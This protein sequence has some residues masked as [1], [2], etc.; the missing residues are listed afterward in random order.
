ME[1]SKTYR[2]LSL[3]GGGSWALTQVKCLRKLFAETFQ[4]PDPTGH[5]V[6]AMF[7]LV[8]ANSGGSLVAA[9]MAEDM[10][11]SQIE[12]IFEEENL[13][14][15][16][17]AKLG[18]FEK[19]LL[20]N[21]ARIFNIGA[22]Y[23]TARKYTALKSMLPS[24]A[25]LPLTDVPKFVA[26]NQVPKTQFLIIAYDYYRNRA[27][28]FRS[29]CHSRAATDIISHHLCQT[30]AKNAKEGVTLVDAIHASSTAPVNYFNEPAVFN[31]NQRQKHYWDGG[32]TGNNN[33]VLTAVTEAI[34]NRSRYQ[35]AHIQVLSL[36][37]G[38]VRQLQADEDCKVKY[39]DLKAKLVSPGL[40]VDISKM[41]M[42]ILNDPPDTASF[43]AYMMLNEGMPAKP[44]DFIRL[45]PVLRPVKTKQG[46]DVFW[47]LPP[48]I[49]IDEFKALKKI[50]MDATEN[51][52]VKLI[53]K[54][55]ENWLNNQGVPN[56]SVRS[57][58]D[59]D[60]LIGHA[61]FNT[62]L[63]DFKSWF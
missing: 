54:M 4:K 42:S 29:D 53:K 11:L 1:A 10:R 60:C 25:A 2:I 36:G 19:S 37:C 38:M 41:S 57:N 44:V 9:A 39:P 24:L 46:N 22:K 15:Q 14:N 5:E 40:L 27:E 35:I 61:N 47:D 18:F 56:Q 3:D 59:L 51:A 26:H 33:P 16:V 63:A 49:S 21:L 8:A 43:I 20:A 31:V 32:V 45:C 58:T 48:G 13:R 7:D 34:C 12:K 17:F 6:L 52:E 62:A 30:E 55:G 23:A 50:G 28:L